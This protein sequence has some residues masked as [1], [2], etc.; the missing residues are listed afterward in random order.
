MTPPSLAYV[1][2]ASNDVEATC[3]AFEVLGLHRN[4][5]TSCSGTVPVYRI[6]RSA[7][8]V[9]PIGHPMLDGE[10]KAG[11]NHI[12]LAID[13][14]DNIPDLYRQSG[15]TAGR[16]EVGLGERALYRLDKADTAG[17][18][19]LLSEPL[20]LKAAAQEG[21]LERIDHIGSASEDV[22]EDERIF[23][24]KLGM[25][26]ESRQTDMEVTIPVESFTSDK[27]GVVYHSR[28]PEPVG[29]LRIAFIT[30]G[31]CEIEFLANFDPSQDGQV[32]YGIS[33]T[34][35]QDQGAISRFVNRR[36]RGLHHIALK[37][38]DINAALD[39]L[40]DAGLELI[41][42]HGRPGS[43]RALIGFVHPKSMGGVLMHLVQRNG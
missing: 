6:G 3:A 34:T 13:K 9:F 40:A 36:G 16:A 31:D 32:N 23:V 4:E 5:L 42:Q 20:D 39:K 25:Q 8:A 15:L 38:T 27:Y 2:L 30:V 17:V 24:G 35:R 14:R 41:D 12:A 18:R 29:G 37:T 43:R 21:L 7:L 22:A 28:E 19:T 1:G 33:G 10:E 26:V 11:V